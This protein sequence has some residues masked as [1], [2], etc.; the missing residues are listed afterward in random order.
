MC[1]DLIKFCNTSKAK[2]KREFKVTQK[3]EKGE[4]LLLINRLTLP[5]IINPHQKFKV[6][7]ISSSTKCQTSKIRNSLRG[8]ASKKQKQN[9]K[10]FKS[11]SQKLTTQKV[12]AKDSDE[13]DKFS[14]LV[15]NLTN[16]HIKNKSEDMT[17]TEN[18]S[19]DIWIQKLVIDKLWSVTVFA[20]QNHAIVSKMMRYINEV[21]DVMSVK[22]MK[23]SKNLTSVIVTLKSVRE[24]VVSIR[25]IIKAELSMKYSEIMKQITCYKITD[26][27]F[28]MRKKFK[29]WAQDNKVMFE[30]VFHDERD[31]ISQEERKRKDK[32]EVKRIINSSLFTH[33]IF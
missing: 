20:N 33:L 15:R 11:M 32:E 5:D 22:Q 12:N 13:S 29:E 24:W 7:M 19:I 23:I 26:E 16:I 31:L 21:L 8:P 27:V 17:T 6:N 2:N 3:W 25:D 18:S 9:S 14:G 30:K 10:S 4:L 28:M 1:E